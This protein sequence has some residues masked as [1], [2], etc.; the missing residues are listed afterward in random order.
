MQAVFVFYSPSHGITSV[1]QVVADTSGPLVATKVQLDH[2]AII[3]G[4]RTVAY[5]AVQCANIVVVLLLLLDAMY[6]LLRTWCARC[7]VTHAGHARCE[8]PHLA[9]DPKPHIQRRKSYES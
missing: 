2:Y 4:S 3:D 1:M 5:L 8:Q 9:Q 7:F 6:G